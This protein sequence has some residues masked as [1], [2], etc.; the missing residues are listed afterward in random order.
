MAVGDDVVCLEDDQPS[1]VQSLA[2][3]A[4]GVPAVRQQSAFAVVSPKDAVMATSIEVPRTE[5]GDGDVMLCTAVGTGTSASTAFGVATIP[6]VMISATE[7]CGTQIETV[8]SDVGSA[9]RCLRAVLAAKVCSTV[10]VRSARSPGCGGEAPVAPSSSAGA[11]TP[12]GSVHA[13]PR[14]KATEDPVQEKLVNHLQKMLFGTALSTTQ[15][16]D[17]C[18]TDVLMRMIQDA[19][20]CGP[21]CPFHPLCTGGANNLTLRVPFLALLTTEGTLR[22]LV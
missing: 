10:S 21:V 9:L 3:T 14:R 18:Y 2:R 8:L 13:A 7:K 11:A 19:F 6:T 17:L 12:W 1:S 5:G 4:A 15:P 20:R 22:L 16:A